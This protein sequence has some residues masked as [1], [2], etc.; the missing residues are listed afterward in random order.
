MRLPLNAFEIQDRLMASQDAEGH[1]AGTEVPGGPAP[2]DAFPPFDSTNFSSQL[3]WLL[4]T[5]GALYLLMSKIALP[6]VA[7]ILSARKDKIDSDL[8]SAAKA[9]DEAAAAAAAH[10]KTLA[11]AKAKAQ[12]VGKAANA[13]LAAQA[14]ARRQALEDDLNA[15]LSAAEAQIA[16]TKTAALANVGAIATE[17]AHAIVQHIT[18]QPADAAAVAAAVAAQKV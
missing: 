17:T 16:A 18:G 14:D 6:R 4:L 9:Q 3:I 15:K 13:E 7:N 12:G 10:E 1:V 5:F 2:Q 8:A 11:D